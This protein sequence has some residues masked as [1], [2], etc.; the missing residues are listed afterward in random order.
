MLREHFKAK[1]RRGQSYSLSHSAFTLMTSKYI[2]YVMDG[3]QVEGS[4]RE[5]ELVDEINIEDIL[6]H[7][8]LYRTV[9][10]NSD[11]DLSKELCLMNA[12]PSMIPTELIQFFGPRLSHISAIRV[13]RYPTSIHG[14]DY[15]AVLT[16]KDADSCALV[17]REF[18]GQVLSSAEKSFCILM[19]VK[20]AIDQASLKIPSNFDHKNEEEQSSCPVC[21]E[22]FDEAHP[23]CL[24]TCCNHRFH[25]NCLLR[26]EGALCPVCR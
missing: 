1:V 8:E 21:L 16:M 7:P 22:Y 6:Q 12:P 10:L 23:M 24:T 9:R 5:V 15:L 14:A 2:Q 26:L 11:Q 4:V 25:M 13:L 20:N 17:R 18:H 3:A 19:P